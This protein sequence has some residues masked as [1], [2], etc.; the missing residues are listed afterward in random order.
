MEARMT[1]AE[2]FIGD[3]IQIGAR[4]SVKPKSFPG[5]PHDLNSMDPAQPREREGLDT[6]LPRGK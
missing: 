2:E 6:V 3:V 1:E 4:K 5:R